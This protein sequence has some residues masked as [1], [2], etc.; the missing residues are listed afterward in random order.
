MDFEYFLCLNNVLLWQNIL[1]PII[2]NS[3]GDKI[4]GSGIYK[5]ENVGQ[6]LV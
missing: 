5:G 6:E 3:W 1:G 2:S 4:F